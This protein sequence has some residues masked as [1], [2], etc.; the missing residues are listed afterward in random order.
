MLAA[1]EKEMSVVRSSP[2]I[3]CVN[4]SV[5][6]GGFQGTE[7]AGAL[8]HPWELHAAILSFIPKVTTLCS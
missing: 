2:T 4:K 8:S 6:N 7:E 3:Q 1:T 5:T